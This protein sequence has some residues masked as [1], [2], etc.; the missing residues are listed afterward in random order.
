MPKRRNQICGPIGAMQLSLARIGWKALHKFLCFEDLEGQQHDYLEIGPKMMAALCKRDW[1]HKL[2]DKAAA[3][4]GIMQGQRPD[5]HHLRRIL[6]GKGPS[7]NALPPPV[8]GKA[9]NHRDDCRCIKCVDYDKKEAEA[10]E[11]WTQRGLIINFVLGGVW[12]K[13]RIY[14]AGY[15]IDD[16]NCELCGEPDS[17][18]HRLWHCKGTQELRNTMLT[19]AE[20][21]WLQ[22]DAQHDCVTDLEG[23]RK[24]LAMK[25]WARHP[26]VGQ[27]KP[28]QKGNEH[29]GDTQQL[30]GKQVIATDGH[31]SKLF[32]PSLNRASWS[33][34]GVSFV[35]GG[36]EVD[37]EVSVSGPVWAS[38][39][40]TSG[41]AERVAINAALMVAD[42]VG[43]EDNFD[44]KVDNLG[45]L[46]G[47]TKPAPWAQ[48]RASFYA[49]LQRSMRST[50]A[51]QNGIATG[52]HVYSH[53]KENDPD[54]VRAASL[55]T[56][57]AIEAN[58]RADAVASAA[59]AQHPALDT[60]LLKQDKWA[61]QVATKVAKFAGA[62]LLLFKAAGKH[63]RAP[64]GERR[65]RRRR[66]AA[67]TLE[68]AHRW[69]EIDG[70]KKFKWRCLD[71]WR[72]ASSSAS[73]RA[74]CPGRPRGFAELEVQAPRAGH[75]L[76]IMEPLS[77]G[78]PRIAICTKC[79]MMCSQG[80]LPGG[81]LTTCLRHT[82]HSQYR[83]RLR[84]AEA[85]KHP[86]RK[87]FGDDIL[88]HA[89]G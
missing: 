15:L 55:E 45:A 27:P 18:H 44:L 59:E 33:L 61:A 74:D 40:Q 3:K 82:P 75:A 71:C 17:L 46:N 34:V 52:Q 67:R 69:A 65:E 13:K 47:L 49:G 63:E 19:E 56:Q 21:A 7:H 53:L 37:D 87:I 5:S 54:K 51:F 62:A 81:L 48:L 10:K 6:I 25:G 23:M 12:D 89:V 2:A 86:E 64:K 83:T 30:Y 80:A 88:Y 68:V 32:H 4:F 84:R 39:P 8:G 60:E 31:C 26:A 35:D 1:H 9:A 22:P 42:A 85:G 79:G 43:I 78:H 72:W 14:D 20:R 77:T 58:E 50:R 24:W 11:W 76:V 38:L 70:P 16:L 57:R 66:E 29:E 73:H 36:S 41:A 28:A